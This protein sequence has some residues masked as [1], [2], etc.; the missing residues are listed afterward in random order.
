MT[1][2]QA[3]QKLVEMGIAEP[4][5]DQ[6][7]AFLNTLRQ[8]TAQ[9]RSRAEQY[10]KDAEKVTE[11]SA[12][13]SETQDSSQSAI[14]NYEARIAELER[15]NREAKRREQLASIGI[16]GDDAAALFTADG[17]LDFVKL[18]QIIQARETT[19]AANKEKEILNSTPNPGG[20]G[21]VSQ[22]AESEDLRI[23]ESLTF[24][25]VSDHAE[26]DRNYYK[27]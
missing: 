13:L 11:L 20:A 6:V 5:A 10:K 12:Q 15:E 9:E 24:G 19:A 18:G 1:R 14:Q 2:E 4:T 7:T 17:G 3:T 26:A 22:V 27:K 16:I 8:E 25:G 21:N 23:A